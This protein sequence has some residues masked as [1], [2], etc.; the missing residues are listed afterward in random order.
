[1]AYKEL[2]IK[3]E[4]WL[5]YP[6][7]LK[8]PTFF[9]RHYPFRGRGIV[10]RL[11]Y[12]LNRLGADRLPRSSENFLFPDDE[13]IALFWP[14]CVRSTGRCYGYKV[15]NGK[16]VQYVKVATSIDE[17]ERLKREV[18]NVQ[19][20]KSLSLTG[21][22]V[23]DVIAFEEKNDVS[24]AKFEAL[25]DDASD[26]PPTDEWLAVV[27]G[28]RH[29][30]A[31]VGLS[32]GDY[33]WHNFKKSNERL[34]ILDWEEMSAEIPKLSDEISLETSFAYYWKGYSLHL[35]WK[36]FKEKY[37]VDSTQREEARL[38]VMDLY[39]RQV[40]MGEILLQLWKGEHPDEFV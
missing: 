13:S 6:E 5:A 23:P 30:I 18:E 17:R 40:S 12:F 29:Q 35:V 38:A 21:F 11:L 10:S 8:F 27:T 28:I 26:L 1:M 2:V 4:R 15:E 39:K 31:K 3:G 37:F 19:Q 36:A 34:W 14:S 22:C 32:H 24:I 9:K 33:A 16:V 7:K 20:I 25:P